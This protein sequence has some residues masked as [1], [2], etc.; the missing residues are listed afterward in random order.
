V[1]IAAVAF[2]PAAPLLVPQV[3]G[4]SA[5]LDDALRKASLGV[6][7]RALDARP[8]QVVVVAPSSSSR[9][10]S[11]DTTWDFAGFGVARTPPD[12]RPVLPWPLGIGAW[13][14]DESG[15][16]GPRRFVGVSATTPGEPSV[17]ARDGGTTVVIA[18]GDGSGCR[19]ERAPGYLDDR[20]EPFDDV[21]SDL[22][23]RGDVAGFGR[24]D[25][26][27]A[28]DLLCAGLPVWQWVASEAAAAEVTT[29]ELAMHV[30][31]YGVGYFVALWSLTS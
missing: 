17:P 11:G 30:A 3:A 22:L 10:W 8:D 31:P 15:W 1:R 24:V 4:G 21:I 7:S 9:E 18:V 12:P 13:L 2:V 6:V 28:G 25:A 5:A 23:A 29:A 26:E 14:L 27:V 16:G 20:A 19:S